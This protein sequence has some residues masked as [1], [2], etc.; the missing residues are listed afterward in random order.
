MAADLSGIDVE[1]AALFLVILAFGLLGALI[2]WRRPGNSVGWVFSALGLSGMFSGAAEDGTILGQLLSGL[3]WFTFYFLTITV[4]PMLYPTGK[5]LSSRWRWLLLAALVAYLCFAFLWIFQARVCTAWDGQAQGPVCVE[6]SENPIG[7]EGIENPENSLPGN[8]LFTAFLLTGIA[9]L[10]SLVLRYRRGGGVERQQ[11]KWLLFAFA[12]LIA[13][14]VVVDITLV[15]SL[16]LRFPDTAYSIV[17]GLVWLGLPT[18]AGL[19][20]FRYGLYDIDRI[21]SRTVAYGLVAAALTLAYLAVVLG[22]GALASWVSPSN[23]NLPLPILATAVVALAFQPVRLKALRV[24]NRLVFGRRRTP[25]EALAGV[26]GGRLEDLLPQIARLATESTA[27]RG[28]II[29]LSDG[30]ELRPAALFPDVGLPPDPVP[31]DDGD[32]PTALDHDH[33]FPLI[34]QDSL[35]GAI[36]IVIGPG[37]GV[38]PDDRRLLDDLAAHAAVTLHGV[39]EAAPLPTG[40][41]TFLMTDIEGSTRLWEEDPDAMAVALR[42]HDSMARRIVADRDGVLV[43]WRGEGDSTFSVFSNAVQAVTAAMA[44]QEALSRHLWATLRP[45]SIRAALHTG[46]A[47]LRERDYYGQTVNRCARLRSL[48]RGG[49]TLVS[50]ATRE[51]AREGLPETL[52]FTDLGE[53]QLKDMSEPE[54]VYEVVPRTGAE[55]LATRSADLSAPA[56]S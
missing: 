15:E 35:L 36:T 52:T 56:Q 37:E 45:I 4:L 1:N 5:T 43:K 34:H 16:G 49:Q 11:L 39:L 46:E 32:L 41:V 50:A 30:T 6:W 40:I 8:I 44:L 48:S 29:W 28:A 18:A 19:A 21:I 20:I 10:V 27:A 3:G 26:S 14:T 13:F 2:L 53:H 24:A 17:S 55:T 12:T 47:E 54:R 42:E 9:G 51:L 22:A 23:V 38:S 31:L 7:I 25:Y 33:A